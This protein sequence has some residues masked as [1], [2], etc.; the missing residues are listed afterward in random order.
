MYFSLSSVTFLNVML[1]GW[2]PIAVSYEQN[3]PPIV[4]QYMQRSDVH[5][6]SGMHTAIKHLLG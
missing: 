4:S 1:S 3:N 2:M 6:K 5:A